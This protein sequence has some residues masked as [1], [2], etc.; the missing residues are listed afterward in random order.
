[1]YFSGE[2]EVIAQNFGLT[3]GVLEEWDN[4]V[5]CRVQKIPCRFKELARVRRSC[6]KCG[7]GKGF[8]EQADLM[9]LL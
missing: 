7:L 3:G 4:S 5:Y 6:E 9:I 8:I 1:M 2:G